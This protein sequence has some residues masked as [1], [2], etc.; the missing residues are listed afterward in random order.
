MLKSEPSVAM[1]RL[2]KVFMSFLKTSIIM[3]NH[4]F[5]MLKTMNNHNALNE[6]SKLTVDENPRFLYVS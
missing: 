2:Q 6:I 3:K 1:K 4:L 5:N